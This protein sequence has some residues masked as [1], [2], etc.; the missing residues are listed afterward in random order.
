CYLPPHERVRESAR[1]APFQ[2]R[3]SLMPIEVLDPIRFLAS[4]H[5]IGPWAVGVLVVLLGIAAFIRERGSTVSATLGLLTLSVSI[6]LLCSAMLYSTRLEPL[7]LWWARAAH[8]G[9]VFI[10]SLVLTFTLTIVQR[11]RELWAFAAGS[12]AL[13]AL[14][15]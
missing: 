4:P 14:F 1:A 2:G 13:S 9:I 8:V 5:S 11:G 15:L 12:L 7:A 10:P 3:V 6:W